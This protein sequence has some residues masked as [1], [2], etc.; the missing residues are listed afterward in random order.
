MALRASSWGGGSPDRSG[1]RGRV[2]GGRGCRRRHSR[3]RVRLGQ[4]VRPDPVA[5]GGARPP[6]CWGARV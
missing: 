2:G 4:G 6:P 1:V 3:G 5:L